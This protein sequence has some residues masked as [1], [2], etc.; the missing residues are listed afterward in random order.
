MIF[1]RYMR[2]FEDYEAIANGYN[3]EQQEYSFR[4]WHSGLC[5]GEFDPLTFIDL[6]L[7][8]ETLKHDR[9]QFLKAVKR[10]RELE[11]KNKKVAFT[12]VD[13]PLSFIDEE[14]E[15]SIAMLE[16]EIEFIPVKA[17]KKPGGGWKD[18]AR[19]SA[20]ASQLSNNTERSEQAAFLLQYFDWP[21][22]REMI[23]YAKLANYYGVKFDENGQLTQVN[24]GEPLTTRDVLIGRI[25]RIKDKYANNKVFEKFFSEPNGLLLDETFV[26]QK[27][28]LELLKSK[29]VPASSEGSVLS[30]RPQLQ[31][32]KKKNDKVVEFNHVSK[33]NDRYQQVYKNCMWYWVMQDQN[34]KDCIEFIEQLNLSRR[35]LRDYIWIEKN[36]GIEK[37]V[38]SLYKRFINWKRKR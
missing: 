32:I 24:H 7:K 1:I 26:T 27:W 11:R 29:K 12:Y 37:L 31:R 23:A 18:E 15:S 2:A 30:E 4:R 19:E 35:E 6:H 25:R 34:P 17:I 33:K 21:R 38:L 9:S 3:S 28:A 5:H 14:F 16:S 10:C 8:P 36:E 13:L 22:N 20:N